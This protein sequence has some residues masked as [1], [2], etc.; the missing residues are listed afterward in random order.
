MEVNL[1][2]LLSEIFADDDETEPEDYTPYFENLSSYAYAKLRGAEDDKLAEEFPEIARKMSEDSDFA[3]LVSEFE[4][5]I[6]D[7]V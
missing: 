2:D 3:E 1:S 7:E 5:S 6:R 4:N